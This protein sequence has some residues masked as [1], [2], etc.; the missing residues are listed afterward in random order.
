MRSIYG[1]AIGTILW[2]TCGFAVAGERIIWECRTSNPTAQP[3]LYLVEWDSRSYVKFS[4]QRFAAQ[5]QA[6][7]EQHAWYWHND[8]SGYY[9]YGLILGPDGKAWYHDFSQAGDDEESQPLDYFLC[10]LEA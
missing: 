6:A 2:V 3:I 4:Y 7:E 5:Y 1:L 8:G 9:R 10:K